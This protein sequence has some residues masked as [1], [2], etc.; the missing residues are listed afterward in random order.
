MLAALLC[1]ARIASNR[2]ALAAIAEKARLHGSAD[3]SR[4]FPGSMLAFENDDPSTVDGLLNPI[5]MPG[6]AP[7]AHEVS[8]RGP[9]DRAGGGVRGRQSRPSQRSSAPECAADRETQ[10][11]TGSHHDAHTPF[12][13]NRSCEPS[14]IRVCERLL[15]HC[16]G[17]SEFSGRARTHGSAVGPAHN[18]RIEH[19]EKR[20]EIT[21]AQSTEERVGNSAL[22]R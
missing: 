12:D 7:K 19:G 1:Q 22:L 16:R 5:F 9:L 14:K 21:V 3:R 10:P 2:S 18:I 11:P 6:G 17:T 20:V 13:Q 15:H 4:F 8:G